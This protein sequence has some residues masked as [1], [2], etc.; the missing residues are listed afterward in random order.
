MAQTDLNDILK[1]VSRSFYLSIRILPT[2][3]RRPVGIAYL[4]AR[5]ADSMTD[6]DQIASQARTDYL[7]ELLTLISQASQDQSNKLSKTLM[8]LINDPGE[9]K[10]IQ[11]LPEIIDCFHQLGNKDKAL[12]Q[13]VVKTLVQGMQN[14]L[15]I[16]NS[17]THI[18]ALK[19]QQCLEKYTYLVAGCVGEFWTKTAI[20]HMPS[21]SHWNTHSQSNLGIE[22]GKA[23]QLTNILRDIAKDAKLGRCYL[24]QEDLDALKL[25]TSQLLNK[26]NDNLFRPIIY[27]YLEQALKYFESAESYLLSTPRTNIRLRLAS[28]WPILIGLKTL[29]LLANK[30]NYLDPDKNIKVQRKWVYSMLLRSILIVGSNSLLKSWIH[31]IK[32][33]IQHKTQYNQ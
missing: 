6:S 24:P 20:A 19:D 29:E 27:K 28:I 23:L 30:E 16:F 15:N 31:S 10:L 18:I 1:R 13:D 3:M 17:E 26:E 25:E 22:F 11:C 8:P 4:L 2:P 14:D 33:H 21:I 9:Y 32:K 5:A 12:V 7:Q